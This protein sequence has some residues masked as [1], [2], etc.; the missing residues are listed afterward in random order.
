MAVKFLICL[1]ATIVAAPLPSVAAADNLSVGFAEA[2]ITPKVDDPKRPVWLA[3]Y[4][5][6]RQATTVHDPI[7]VR[8]LVLRDGR[9]KIA[10]ACADLVGLQY[11]TVQRIREQLKD[12]RYVLVSST[13]NHEAPDVVGIWGRSFAQRGVDDQYLQ[14]IV[15]RTVAAIRK[16]DEQIVAAEAAYGTAEDETLLGDSRLPDVRDGIL[17]VLKFSS[18]GK[19]AGLLVQWNCHPECLGSKNKELTADF[20]ASTVNQLKKRYDCPVVYVSGAVGGLMAPPDGVVRDAQGKELLEGDFAYSQAYGEAVAGLA[21]KAVANATPITLTPFLVSAKPVAVRVTNAYYKTAQ[22]LGVVQR[23]AIVWQG[24]TD[25]IGSPLTGKAGEQMAVESEVAYLR[26]GEL[27]IAGM[28]GE[29]YPEL[30]YGKYPAQAEVGVDFPD[31]PLEP[32]V[33]G[34]LPGK[35][36]LLIGLANDELGYI[37]PR[38]QWDDSAPF[39]YGRRKSQYGEINSC[40]SDVAPLLM[41][42]FQRRVAEAK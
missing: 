5:P 21:D 34:T 12:F 26:L 24:D 27:S 40:G 17:R 38:R 1:C 6:G 19:T 2:D 28:P 41:E 22:A 4:G 9:D 30:V 11:P 20:V 3:G 18:H 39:A 15:D 32:S 10:I 16:A 31:A 25:K 13:H 14:S 23:K 7:F 29:V 36:W 35:K 37:I 42:A 33:A 8:A